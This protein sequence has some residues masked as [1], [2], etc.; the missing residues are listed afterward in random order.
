[1]RYLGVNLA[2]DEKDLYT[3]N[4]KPLLREIKDSLN[5]WIYVVF[6][7][8]TKQYCQGVSSPIKLPCDPA[9]PLLGIHPEK[10]HCISMQSVCPQE[11]CRA[12]QG[13][14]ELLHLHLVL[15]PACWAQGSL[16]YCS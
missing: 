8:W 6:M 13:A 10:P 12:G 3:E 2:K 15:F 9:S 11:K 7:D 1:M 5:K 16:G 14:H 4:H